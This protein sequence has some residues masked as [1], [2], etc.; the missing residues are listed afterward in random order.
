LVSDKRS[1][2]EVHLRDADESGI[3]RAIRLSFTKSLM[4]ECLLRLLNE[5]D[6]Q[7]L[8]EYSL[9]LALIALATVALLSSVSRN[10]TTLW[11]DCS[12]AFSNALS[13]AS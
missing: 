1:E 4:K 6:G 5:E 9:L 3:S 10:V 11:Q 7:D 12:N 13:G 2:I 8:V